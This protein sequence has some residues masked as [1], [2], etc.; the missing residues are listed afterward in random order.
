MTTRKA[1]ALTLASACIAGAL[2]ACSSTKGP[3]PMAPVVTSDTIRDDKSVRREDTVTVQ[4][5]VTAVDQKSR[6][7]TLRGPDGEEST[8][9]VDDSV[10][11]LP[12]VKKGDVVTA[13]YYRA[14]AAR[15]RKP[16]EAKPGIT[17]GAELET[18]APGERPAGIEAETVQITAT[19]T[20][21]DRERQEITLR[22][23]KG[24]SVVVAVKDPANLEKVKKGD[25]VEITYTEAVAISVDKASR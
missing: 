20:K 4:A 5:T 10:K 19:A 15:V 22:G 16:G 13:A 14:I 6:M 21:V 1:A 18:A 23:P 8:F 3:E 2:G 12:Q 7:V 9:R 24:K 11:N 25:L 17:G